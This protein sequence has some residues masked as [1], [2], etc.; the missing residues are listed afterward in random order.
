MQNIQLAFSSYIS[1]GEVVYFF[2]YHNLWEVVPWEILF[3]ELPMYVHM[4]F[5]MH[6]CVCGEG[7]IVLQLLSNSLKQFRLYAVLF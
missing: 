4:C 6:V 7:P 2:E 5:V 1:C 3:N